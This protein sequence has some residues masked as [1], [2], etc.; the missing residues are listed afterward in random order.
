MCFCER[1]RLL[2]SVYF[3]RQCLRKNSKGEEWRGGK[4]M[5]GRPSRPCWEFADVLAQWAMSEFSVLS[6]FFLSTVQ[7]DFLSYTI[8]LSIPL[9]F[10][11]SLVDN[12]VL[13]SFPSQFYQSF[14]TTVHLFSHPPNP[15]S[16]PFLSRRSPSIIWHFHPSIHFLFSASICPPTLFTFYFPS[17]SPPCA[18]WTTRNVTLTRN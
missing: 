15:R 12:Y 1:G 2:S 9:A 8:C 18:C 4:R 17:V 16:Q 13:F 3:T 11:L 5:R 10:P 14:P 6:H 7:P